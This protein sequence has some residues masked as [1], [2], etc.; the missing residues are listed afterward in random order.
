MDP[1][2]PSNVLSET[3][4]ENNPGCPTISVFDWCV[5]GHLYG[6]SAKVRCPWHNFYQKEPEKWPA[7]TFTD[8]GHPGFNETAWTTIDCDIH[9]YKLAVSW[10]NLNR[11]ICQEHVNTF[12]QDYCDSL[13][14]HCN[15]D[16]LCAAAG[17]ENV[18]SSLSS[19][20][21]TDGNAQIIN[22]LQHLRMAKMIM[23]SGYAVS[24][25]ATTLGSILMLMLR[26]LRCTRIYIHINLLISF[27]MRALLWLF[28]GS[29][30]GS[31]FVLNYCFAKKI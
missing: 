13:P 22:S 16:P 28:H 27:M 10:T 21:G 1:Q 7:H 3:I 14:P 8:F 19:V 25:I 26:R 15:C 11:T 12:E 23:V 31:K 2:N 9:P 4:S 18:N 5:P 29:V 24:L 17:V 20:N 30:Y 6:E